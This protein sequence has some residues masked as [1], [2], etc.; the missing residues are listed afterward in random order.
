LIS[1]VD[2]DA[3]VR[4]ATL[5]L[6]ES[7]GY[8]AAAFASAEEFL[9]SGRL[10]D[11]GCVITDVRMAGLSGIELQRRLADAAPHI[12]VIVVTALSEE[13]IRSAA[14]AGGACGFFTKPANENGLIDCIEKALHDCRRN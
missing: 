13:H 4:T 14:L 3:S 5:D 10:Q 2:D 12:P 7:H 11:T 6:L 8:A 1:I 9:R